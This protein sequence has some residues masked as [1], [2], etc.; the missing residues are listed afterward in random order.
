MRSEVDCLVVVNDLLRLPRVNPRTISRAWFMVATGGA[1]AVDVL[2]AASSSRATP[3][4]ASL[5]HGTPFLS[6]LR[7]F[8]SE[9]TSPMKEEWKNIGWYQGSELN[10]LMEH[11]GK[12]STHD[13]SAF[14]ATHLREQCS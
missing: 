13:C 14:P 10:T 6:T 8:G 9:N 12:H 3:R 2:P 1:A 7:I 5:L 4:V 11:E